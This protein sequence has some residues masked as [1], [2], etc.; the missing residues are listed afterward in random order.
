MAIG[1]SYVKAGVKMLGQLPKLLVGL[2]VETLNIP[3]IILKGNLIL[4]AML[5]SMAMVYGI[6]KKMVNHMDMLKA[7]GMVDLV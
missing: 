7:N 1:I 2:L 6:S 5:G 3:S 4:L